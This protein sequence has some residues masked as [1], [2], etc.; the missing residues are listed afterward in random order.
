MAI[1]LMRLSSIFLSQPPSNPVGSGMSIE[2]ADRR[3]IHSANPD[4]GEEI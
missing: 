2:L 1:Q 4:R 3:N